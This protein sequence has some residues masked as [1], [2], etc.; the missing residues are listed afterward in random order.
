MNISSTNN[1]SGSSLSADALQSSVRKDDITKF[2]ASNLPSASSTA[3]VPG[4]DGSQSGVHSNAKRLRAYAKQ[5]ATRIQH[6]LSSSDLS[7]RQ[8]ADIQQQAEKFRALMH[9]LEHAYLPGTGQGTTFQNTHEE[10]GSI[11]TAIDKITGSGASAAN[12]SGGLD[13]IA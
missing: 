2:A 8:R 6:A 12:P 7:P 5:V 13:T 3:Q 9:R 1:V 10:I 11:A 4:G